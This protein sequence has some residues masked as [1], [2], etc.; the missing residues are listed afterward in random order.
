M[1]SI[2]PGRGPSGM[3]LIGSIIA[4]VF[5]VLTLIIALN[6]SGSVNEFSSYG[7][8][9]RP[10]DTAFSIMPLFVVLFIVAAIAGAIYN[11]RNYKGKDRYSIVD[12]VDSK[13]EG[14]PAGIPESDN[15]E[16]ADRSNPNGNFCTDCGYKLAQS[17][18]FCP[19]CGRNLSKSE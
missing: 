8:G 12:I 14:D 6:L 16:S 18:K 13:E 1:K 11:Y 5:G 3:G 10:V 9:F 7:M 2:K 19:G 4:V 15:G 17:F